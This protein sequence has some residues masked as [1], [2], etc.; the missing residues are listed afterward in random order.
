MFSVDITSFLL[1]ITGEVDT[2][3]GVI[4]STNDIQQSMAAMAVNREKFTIFMG[5][6]EVGDLIVFFF[7]TSFTFRLFWEPRLVAL[8][9]LWELA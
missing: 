8:L 5:T 7:F 6:D 1:D 4:Y 9:V 2:F 3:V